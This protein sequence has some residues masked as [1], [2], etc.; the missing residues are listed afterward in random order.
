MQLGAYQLVLLTTVAY[1]T[2]DFARSHL[3]WMGE[4]VGINFDSD[5]TMC[6]T[7]DILRCAIL[8]MSL[9]L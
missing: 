7:C 2:L 6:S 9:A 1:N 8:W 4:H 3:E 5:P